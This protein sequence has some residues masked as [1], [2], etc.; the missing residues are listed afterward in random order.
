MNKEKDKK[1]VR[2]LAITIMVIV[3]IFQYLNFD[4]EYFGIMY[5]LLG[6]MIIL[7]TV[8]LYRKLI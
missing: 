7:L 5:S 3:L 6:L 8:A 1:I 4:G 2:F